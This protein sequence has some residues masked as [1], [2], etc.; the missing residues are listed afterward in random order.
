[1][2]CI[3]RQRQGNKRSAIEKQISPALRVAGKTSFPLCRR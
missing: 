2:N 3:R 1:M